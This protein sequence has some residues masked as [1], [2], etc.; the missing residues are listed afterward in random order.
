MGNL[1]FRFIVAFVLSGMAVSS[2]GEDHTAAVVVLEI[3]QSDEQSDQ[4]LKSIVY[5]LVAVELEWT[6]FDVQPASSADVSTS[7]KHR[8]RA[9]Y[10]TNDDGLILSLAWHDADDQTVLAGIDR[11]L[12]M[13]LGM[14]MLVAQAVR[15]L[16]SQAGVSA[17]EPE[18]A[19]AGGSAAAGERTDVEAAGER[20][21]GDGT[22]DTTEVGGHS[23]GT[24][25][26]VASSRDTG[27]YRQ[28]VRPDSPPGTPKI[29]HTRDVRK[30]RGTFTMAAGAGAL[31]TVG[32]A[33]R[34][35]SVAAASGA[36]FGYELGGGALAFGVEMTA[37]RFYAEG[38]VRSSLGY[39]LGAGA[40]I[41]LNLGS[42]GAPFLYLS[43]GPAALILDIPELGLVY[44]L[45]P[46]VRGGIGMPVQ[47]GESMGMAFRVDYAVFF[48]GSMLVMGL[49]P[50]LDVVLRL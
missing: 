12:D 16:I 46:N 3:Q 27:D 1:R 40:G 13:T 50:S 48:E 35:F 32:E 21:G 10:R 11:E 8:I 37:A 43:G 34:L 20:P 29:P 18:S 17:L 23:D 26:T 47:L 9:Q 7:G 45:I 36:F 42:P 49:A 39:L 15:Q 44:E 19:A 28:P 6:G 30:R 25:P 5:D 22:G 31:L 14:D 33:N 24:P 38:I 2:F 41:R 4:R